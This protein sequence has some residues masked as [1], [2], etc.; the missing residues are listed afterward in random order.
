MIQKKPENTEEHNAYLDNMHT[1]L[2]L[3]GECMEQAHQF[4]KEQQHSLPDAF[5][6][7][8]W[9]DAW[10]KIYQD[11]QTFYQAQLELMQGYGTIWYQAWARYWGGETTPVFQETKK[12]KRFKDPAWQ[13]NMVFHFIKQSYLFGVEWSNNLIDTLYADDKKQAE[14]MHFFT[15]QLANAV[16]PTNFVLTNPEVLKATFES[17]GENLVKGLHNLLADFKNSKKLFHV[18]TTSKDAFQLGVNIATSQ[19][20]VIYRNDLMEVL[21]YTPLQAQNYQRPLLILPAWINKFY[22]LDLSPNNSFVKWALEQGYSVFVISWVNP[23]KTL[24]E[25]S[26]E[27][28]LEEG[29][30]KAVD[31]IEKVTGSKAI[32]AMGYCLGGTLLACLLAYM[33]KKKDHRIKAATLVTTLIDFSDAGQISAFMDD[34]QVEAIKKH[35]TVTGFLEGEVMSLVFSSLRSNELIWSFVVNNYLLGRDPMPFDI[36][37]WNADNTRL[38]ANMYSFYL[39]NMYLNNALA[40]ANGITLRKIGIDM[41]KITTPCYILSCQEDHIAP[42]QTTFQTTRL[43]ANSKTTF[44]LSG[45]GH[46][47]GVVNPPSKHKYYYYEYQGKEETAQEWLQQAKQH[48]G[49]WWEHWHDWNRAYSGQMMKAVQPGQGALKSLGAAPGTYVLQ[50]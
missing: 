21:H 24:S 47:A 42:W 11:P 20:E 37:Y 48:E 43:L 23:D 3:Y 31:V 36:L 35:I 16:S 2:S 7:I 45:S 10:G 38:P 5:A 40:K 28:Y 9:Q 22:I 41:T 6:T 46:V 32:T 15:N 25:K 19:G 34:T 1:C 14:K 18:S 29:A 26:F 4:W 39:K 13:E 50:T 17:K 12:D 8:P 33:A 30:L 44:V 49:S 27:D